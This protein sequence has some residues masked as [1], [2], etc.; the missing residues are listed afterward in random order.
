[1]TRY[2][3]GTTVSADRSLAEIQNILRRYGAD[4][5]GYAEISGIA[6]VEFKAHDRYVRFVVTMPSRTNREFTST[7]QGRQRSKESA[8]KAWEAACRQRWRALA[9]CIK[10]KLEAVESGIS[11]FEDEFL[12]QIVLPNGKTV[13]EMVRP[14]V[15]EAYLTGSVPT[16]LGLP[17]KSE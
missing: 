17:Y 10:A 4:G 3:A 14:A 8:Y 1:M 6:K 13:S 2:A 7:S 15:A 11:Q 9:L 12:A 5:F 16:M